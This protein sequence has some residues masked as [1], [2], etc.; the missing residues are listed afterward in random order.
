MPRTHSFE[1]TGEYPFRPVCGFSHSRGKTSSRPRKRLRKSVTFSAWVD[2]ALD[3]EGNLSDGTGFGRVEAESSTAS[4]PLSSWSFARAS[5]RSFS[6]RARRAS[7][8]EIFLRSDS[9][10]DMSQGI[11]FRASFGE[12]ILI[13]L[14]GGKCFG[15]DVMI[16]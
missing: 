13:P 10:S 12:G 3:G 4:R 9:R 14:T 1:Q 6:T 16:A 5:V 11:S 2:G 7:S 8:S 15:F